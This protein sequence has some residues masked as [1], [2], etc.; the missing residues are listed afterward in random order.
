MKDQYIREV[1]KMI[2]LPNRAKREVLRDLEEAF[3][4][5]AEHGETEEQVIQRLGS[6]KEFAENLNEQINFE[7]FTQEHKKR[8][9]MLMIICTFIFSMLLFGIYAV[10]KAVTLTHKIE[11]IIGGADGLTAIF[12]ASAGVDVS[13]VVVAL[14]IAAFAVSILLTIRYIYDNRNDKK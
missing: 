1:E 4:S 8:K 11:G 3:A 14:G 5:A 10:L 9:Q 13:L 12:V 6:P 2:P 7:R